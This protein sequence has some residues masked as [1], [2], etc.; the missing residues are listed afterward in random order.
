MFSK[1]VEKFD[2]LIYRLIYRPESDYQLNIFEL[3]TD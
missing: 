2:F 1:N 3:F